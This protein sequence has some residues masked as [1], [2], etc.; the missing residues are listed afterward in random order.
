MLAAR[1]SS[2]DKMIDLF[3]GQ[4]VTGLLCL[5]VEI[6]KGASS[7]SSLGTRRQSLEIQC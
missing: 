6:F 2:V 3:K 4:A 7:R 1:R 5:T